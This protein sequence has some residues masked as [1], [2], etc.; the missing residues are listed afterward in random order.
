MRLLLGIWLL[1]V[2]IGVGGCVV[3][4]RKVRVTGSRLLH[5]K[6]GKARRFL[7]GEDG[8]RQEIFVIPAVYEE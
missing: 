4:E 6:P 3:E 5:F 8:K 7:L 2:L 1:C